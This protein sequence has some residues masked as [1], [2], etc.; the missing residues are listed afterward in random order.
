MREISLNAKATLCR[1]F[2]KDLKSHEI[3]ACWSGQKVLLRDYIARLGASQGV[4]EVLCAID[5]LRPTP[6]E[7]LHQTVSA[8]TRGVPGPAEE[9]L[10][11]PSLGFLSRG[12]FAGLPPQYFQPEWNGEIIASPGN[13]KELA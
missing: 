11:L 8:G 13:A 12:Q 7:P 10:S 4:S 3:P 1:P 2:T 6:Q 9:T 5:S